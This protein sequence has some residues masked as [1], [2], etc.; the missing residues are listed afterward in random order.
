MKP[1]VFRA[2]AALDVRRA[3][4][5]E[6]QRARARADADLRA[7]V[8]ATARAGEALASAAARARDVVGQAIAAHELSWHCNWMMGLERGEARARDHERGR[9][10]AASAAALRAQEARRAL[11][12]LERLRDRAWRE[13][14]DH[15]RREDQKAL[16][17][18]GSL[19]HAVRLLHRQEHDR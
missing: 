17:L 9:R 6:A 10:A 5:D 14:H 7:A 1:F 2:Q 8:A 19:Q 16:D 15:G 3:Q 4:E 12:T 13:W 11:R 18:L